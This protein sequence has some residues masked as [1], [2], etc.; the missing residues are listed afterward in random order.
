MVTYREIQNYIK[1]KYGFTV[2]SC[3][4]AHVKEMSGLDVKVSPRRE[5]I[6]K[7]KVPCPESKIEPIKNT[8][9]H[10]GMI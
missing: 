3:W 6:N 10:F 8:L 9:R 7:R 5:D 1:N 2:K 4:I